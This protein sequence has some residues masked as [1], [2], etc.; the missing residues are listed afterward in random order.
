MTIKPTGGKPFIDGPGGPADNAKAPAEDIF[1]RKLQATPVE[2]KAP[3]AA[4]VAGRYSRADLKDAG[5]LDKIVREALGEL[6]EAEWNS[7]IPISD[8]D[9]R[10]VVEFMAGDPVVRRQVERW[11]EKVLK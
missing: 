9:K 2:S 11:L 10:S 7:T 6:V 8:A 5:A 1:A 4:G 3:G